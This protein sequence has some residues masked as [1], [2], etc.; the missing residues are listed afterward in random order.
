[1][2]DLLDGEVMLVEVGGEDVL[3]ANLGGEFYAIGDECTHAGGSLSQGDVEGGVVECPVHGS[4]FDIR[5]GENTGPPAAEPVQAY[6]VRIEGEDI[7]VGPP[8]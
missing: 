3:L 1:M 2:N 4:P 5:T 8:Q 6:P 7:L